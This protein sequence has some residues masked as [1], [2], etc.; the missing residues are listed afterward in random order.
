M[1][2]Q[3]LFLYVTGTLLALVEIEIEG[4][5]GW[6]EKIPTWYRTTGFAGRLWGVFMGG[7]PLTGY[8]LFLTCL[9]L[10]MLHQKFFEGNWTLP[11]EFMVLANYFAMA[12]VWDV[13]WFILNPNYGIENFKKGNIWWFAKSPWVLGLFPIDYFWGWATSVGMA[14]LSGLLSHNVNTIIKSQLIIL[15]ILFICIFIT[16]YLSHHYVIW[17]I[18]MGK[19]DDRTKAGIFHRLP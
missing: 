12:I 6:A 2:Y 10:L 3:A 15:G 17:R 4:K 7:K 5:Y 1:F 8:H 13:S 11:A 9:P 16:I 14:T 18:N 19:R